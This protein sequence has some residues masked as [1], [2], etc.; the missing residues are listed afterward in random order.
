LLSAEL[1]Q[2][3]HEFNRVNVVG[4]DDQLGLLVL[5]QSGNVVQT[6]LEHLRLL[7]LLL[8][9]LVH[10][11]LGL[12]QESGFLLLLGLGG[13]L[14]Q[15]FEESLGLVAVHG[16]VELVQS[17][18]H[19]RLEILLGAYFETLEQDTL[20]SLE[21]DVAGPSHETGHVSFVLHVTS[22]AEILGFGLE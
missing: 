9:L 19:L 6:E 14:L 8:D 22:D 20:L 4:D 16:G 5:Y 2:P 17:R 3:E 15:Q 21:Q 13:V 12:L 10:L 18:G 11:L 7:V 1:G